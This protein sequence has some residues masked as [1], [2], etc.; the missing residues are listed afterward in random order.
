[1]VKQSHGQI[2]GKEDAAA[3]HEAMNI[4]LQRYRCLVNGRASS[5]EEKLKS[6]K[7]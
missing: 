4:L 2:D 6:G 1:M 3:I 7:G 5:N